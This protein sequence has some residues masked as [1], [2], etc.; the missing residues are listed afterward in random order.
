MQIKNLSAFRQLYHD[1]GIGDL[2][3][4]CKHPYPGHFD[5]RDNHDEYNWLRVLHRPYVHILSH[6]QHVLHL[7]PLPTLWLLGVA[8]VLVCI[9][10]GLTTAAKVPT[11]P[12]TLFLFK[13]SY[14][15][16][17]LQTLSYSWV[18]STAVQQ[19]MMPLAVGQWTY[20]STHG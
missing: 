13:S 14:R 6:N 17:C 12:G 7:K 1:V 20:D 9:Y 11:R 3:D 16:L 10:A 19:N 8:V 2:S 4:V 15:R 18:V 5:S